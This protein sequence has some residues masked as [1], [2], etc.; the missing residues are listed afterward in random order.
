MRVDNR[1]QALRHSFDGGRALAHEQ[2]QAIAVRALL[3]HQKN[4]VCA[5]VQFDFAA[6]RGIV[7]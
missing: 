6:L 7:L 5:P 4:A 1:A 3:H 2:R